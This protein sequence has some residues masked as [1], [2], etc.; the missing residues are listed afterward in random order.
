[1]KY[2]VYLK[3]SLTRRPARHLTVFVIMTCALVL[4][5]LISIYLDSSEHGERLQLLE[6]T[7]GETFHIKNSRE[8]DCAIFADI[9]GLSE[10][11]FEDGVIYLHI[12]DDTQWRDERMERYYSDQLKQ[13]I[14][15]TDADCC[16]WVTVQDYYNAHGILKDEQGLKNRRIIRMFNVFVMV[17]SALVIRS[18]YKSHLRRF[19]SDVGILCSCGADY[20]QVRAIFL[21]ELVFLFVFSAVSAVF[22]SAAIMKLI[23]S[24]YMEISGVEG[25]AWVI[26]RMDVRNTGLCVAAFGVILLLVLWGS[27]RGIGRSSLRSMIQEDGQIRQVK[28]RE[29][30]KLPMKGTPEKSLSRLWRQRTHGDYRSCLFL[31]ISVMTVFLFLFDYLSIDIDLIEAPRDYELDVHKEVAIWGSFTQEDVDF[32]EQL[33]NVD[34]AAFL[35]ELPAD[36]YAQSSEGG[37]TYVDR[38]RIKLVDPGRHGQ[39]EEALRLRFS[40][41]AFEIRNFQKDVEVWHQVTKGIY[42]MFLFLFCALGLLLLVI[43]YMK[44]YE[45]IDDCRGTIRTLSTIGASGEVI[46][47]SF[48]RQAVGAALVAAAVPPVVSTALICRVAS[49]IG[50]RFVVDAPLVATHA[51]VGILTVCGFLLPVHNRL[52]QILKHYR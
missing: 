26:F 35:Q 45:Y 34:H 43:L 2:L 50:Q 25:L 17:L 31:S 40:G 42:L 8:A 21:V 52:K 30:R 6:M 4:P 12:L 27:L 46:R 44:L 29:R 39:T 24:A 3:E 15:Q 9:E 20:G 5:L 16:M 23:F 37:G 48:I 49:S 1:M 47:A 11:R 41:N 36:F 14:E 22:F 32:V 38:I 33:E 18:A 19:R 13:R 28:R 7:K 51:T 10:P